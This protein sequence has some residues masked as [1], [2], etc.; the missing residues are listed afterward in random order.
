M[1]N[2]H[3]SCADVFVYNKRKI[4]IYE[5]EIEELEEKLTYFFQS[6]RR[7]FLS[8]EEIKRLKSALN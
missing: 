7:A 2:S 4:A 3:C 5:K 8:K 1:G 6:R